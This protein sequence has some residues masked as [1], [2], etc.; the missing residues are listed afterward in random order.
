MIKQRLLVLAGSVLLLASA[1]NAQ[2]KLVE[3]ITKKGSEIVIPYE[4]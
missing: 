3:K 2:T 4:K 1:G